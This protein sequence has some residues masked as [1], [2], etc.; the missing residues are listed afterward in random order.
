MIRTMKVGHLQ[1]KMK[2]IDLS[3]EM[4]FTALRNLSV[5]KYLKFVLAGVHLELVQRQMMT[6]EVPCGCYC[7]G[8]PA[9]VR[10]F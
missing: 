5:L 8:F 1:K 2:E 3:L 9:D 4:F 10:H 6:A 7:M